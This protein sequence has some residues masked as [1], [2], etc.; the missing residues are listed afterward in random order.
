M[1]K[2]FYLYVV[3]ADCSKN[4]KGFEPKVFRLESNDKNAIKAWLEDSINLKAAIISHANLTGVKP[5]AVFLKAVYADSEMCEALGLPDDGTTLEDV[6]FHL[7]KR[8]FD[9]RG[10]FTIAWTKEL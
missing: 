1:N 2:A 9:R 4:A 5:G 3:Y 8:W 7:F 10:S 6:I